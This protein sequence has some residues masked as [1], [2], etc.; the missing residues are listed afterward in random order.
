MAKNVWYGNGNMKQRNLVPPTHRKPRERIELGSEPS[1][2][3]C[4]IHP[5]AQLHLL[6]VPQPLKQQHWDQCSMCEPM[7]GHVSFKPSQVLL[8][9][10]DTEKGDFCEEAEPP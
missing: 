10:K 7:R 4:D 5:P 8:F 1:G 6:K 9:C 3:P 2:S